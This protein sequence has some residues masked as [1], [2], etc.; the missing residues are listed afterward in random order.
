MIGTCRPYEKGNMGQ[1]GYIWVDMGSKYEV[2]IWGRNMGRKM[3]RNMGR[4]MS[5]MGLFWNFMDLVFLHLALVIFFF[6]LLSFEFFGIYNQVMANNCFFHF[7]LQDFLW[8]LR[9]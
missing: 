7:H 6:L 3:D 4:N 5:R 9:I 1:N 8:F 2:E